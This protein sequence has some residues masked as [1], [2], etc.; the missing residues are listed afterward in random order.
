MVAVI[1]PNV[2][3]CS[4]HWLVKSLAWKSCYKSEGSDEGRGKNL[5]KTIDLMDNAKLASRIDI[6]DPRTQQYQNSKAQY[7]D[8]KVDKVDGC[9][10]E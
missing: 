2:R 3:R 6:F 5:Q 7:R 9:M 1:R 10:P 8:R 4:T